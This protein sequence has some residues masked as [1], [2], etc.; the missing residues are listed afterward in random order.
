M[1][2]VRRRA[3][4]RA[5]AD[6]R[7]PPTFDIRIA[8]TRVSLD[9]KRKLCYTLLYYTIQYYTRAIVGCC[10]RPPEVIMQTTAESGYAIEPGPLEAPSCR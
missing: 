7:G 1:G 3:N 10:V 2:R 5:R 8:L 9:N 4:A 6:V